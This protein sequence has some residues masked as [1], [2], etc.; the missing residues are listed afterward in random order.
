[1]HMLQSLFLSDD[2]S[3]FFG[4]H[5]HPSS[6]DVNV[7]PLWTTIYSNISSQWKSHYGTRHRWTKPLISV[8]HRHHA[9]VNNHVKT[10]TD[11]HATYKYTQISSYSS[12]IATDNNTVCTSFIIL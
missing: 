9:Y 3:T 5:Y 6:Y 7:N 12:T 4:Y 2:C 8:G 10:K 1:M 11:Q